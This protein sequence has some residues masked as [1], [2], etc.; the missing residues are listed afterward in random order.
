[1]WQIG[2]PIIGITVNYRLGPWG[3]LTSREI[4]GLRQANAGLRDQRKALEWIQENI[5]AFGG[6]PS[7]VTI[8]GESAQV[9]LSVI[10]LSD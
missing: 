10:V 1:M 5:S 8:A 2:K 7:K 4:L 9:L 6:D 3:F